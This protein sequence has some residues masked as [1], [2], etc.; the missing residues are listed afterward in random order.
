V[1][2][3]GD[4]TRLALVTAAGLFVG[5]AAAPEF[6]PKAFTRPALLQTVS[7]AVAGLFVGMILASGIEPMLVSMPIG[8]LLGWLTPYWVRYLQIP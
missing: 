3:F 8:G 1:V 6:A 4:W 7:G 5:L 2:Y